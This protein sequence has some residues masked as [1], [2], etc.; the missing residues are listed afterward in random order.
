MH[1]KFMR[2][3]L[4][5][6]TLCFMYCVPLLAETLYLDSHNGNDANPGTKEQPLK[7]LTRTA[8]LVNASTE[9]GPTLIKLAPGLYDLTEKVLFQNPRAYSREQRLI[10]EAVI[11]PDDPAWRHALMPVIISTEQPAQMDSTNESGA[12][13]FGLQIEVSHVTIRGLKFL[14]S[15]AAHNRYYPIRRNGKSLDD[16][17]V[18][19]C[20]FVA[21]R[22]TSPIQ[23]AVIANGHGL[24][25]EHC[26]FYD[27]KNPAVFWR[28]EGGTSKG[29]AMRYCLVS[30]AYQ[31]GVWL[32]E[33]GEDFD[34]HHNVITNC[35]YFL[36]REASNRRTYRLHDSMVT[37]FRNYSGYGTAGGP[38]KPSGDEV[39]VQEINIVKS[40]EIRIE[41]DKPRPAELSW[42]MPKHYLHIVPGTL[43]SEL[44]AGLFS[45]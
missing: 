8:A 19:Q 45:Q 33:T 38:L 35:E 3:G 42:H 7:T 14:G 12:S 1:I 21:N 37:N 29:N 27:C 32:V 24:V 9:A 25:L 15:A 10:I 26:I 17:V 40:G 39:T 30:G 36:I 23:V 28:A 31:S 16:L 41:L 4:L 6:S 22:H 11:M 13:T 20:V 18:S 5:V 44:R 34:F 2:S 43:G